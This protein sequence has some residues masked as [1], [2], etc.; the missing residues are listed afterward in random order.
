M[1][2]PIQSLSKTHVT[3]VTR[4]TTFAK[5]LNSLAFTP[6]T[7]LSNYLYTLCDTALMCNAQLKLRSLLA[8]TRGMWSQS[9]PRGLRL[10]NAGRGIEC[11]ANRAIGDD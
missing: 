10:Q 4:L 6:V 8:D 3:G 2:K 1:S 9:D 7:Q 5:H 11:Y